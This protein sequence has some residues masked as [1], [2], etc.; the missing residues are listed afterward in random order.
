MLGGIIILIN[1]IVLSIVIRLLSPSDLS[2][3]ARR[4]SLSTLHKISFIVF[5]SFTSITWIWL[6]VHDIMRGS[7]E[8]MN[9]LMPSVIP[10]IA[11]GLLYIYTAVGLGQP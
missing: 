3:I 6:G 4:P 2:N 9:T 5:L 10:L 8:Y 7:E 11:Q 1:I